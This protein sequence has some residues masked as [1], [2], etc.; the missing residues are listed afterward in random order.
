MRGAIGP[1]CTTVRVPSCLE[2]KPP[3]TRLGIAEALRRT[4]LS[5]RNHSNTMIRTR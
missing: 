1:S 5:Y 3:S 4:I 2:I